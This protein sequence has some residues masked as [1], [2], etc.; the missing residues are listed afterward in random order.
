MTTVTKHKLDDRHRP[1]QSGYV[2]LIPLV[3]QRTIASG[4]AASSDDITCFDLPAYYQ[5][6]AGSM[7]VSAT[8]GSSCTI[9]LRVG[10][11]AITAATSAGG[12]DTELLSALPAISASE[13]AINV[14]I[15]GA[16]VTAAA[17]ITVC[18]LCVDTAQAR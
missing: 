5:V 6:V 3:W 18:L 11:T 14:L 4:D 17:V 9:Q 7:H 8:L 10:A 2:N 12:A 15:G 13:Q 16:N 1:S